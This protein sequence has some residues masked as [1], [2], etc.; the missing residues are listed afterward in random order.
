[1][2]TIIINGKTISASGSSVTV[3]NGRVIVDGKDVTP[4][5]KEIRIEVQGD[6]ESLQADV[7][8]S[9]SVTGAVKELTTTSGNVNCGD[10][11]GDIRTT[12]GGVRCKDVRGS[13]ET[14]SGDVEVGTI[15]GKVRTVS[16]SVG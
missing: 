2:A 6:I 16:G 15:H 1:M 13:V 7:C 4:D 10:V 3:V 14:V 12:S 5:T 8:N 9:V 11:E